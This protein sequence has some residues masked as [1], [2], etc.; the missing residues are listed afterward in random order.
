MR[1][2][3]LHGHAFEVVDL[4][5]RQ[6]GRQYLVLLRS[7]EN[8]HHMSWRLL[9]CLQKRVEGGSRK[10]VHLV[11]NE[12]LVAS[13][14][15]R[16]AR[17]FH[18][19]LYVFDRVVACGVKLKDVERAL[20]IKRLTT[21]THVARLAIGCWLHAVYS[22][23]KDAGT[24]GLAHTARAT[25]QIGMRKLAALDSIL[26]RGGERLLSHHSVEC[27]RAVLTCR[28]YVVFHCCCVFIVSCRQSYEKSCT[29]VYMLHK[30]IGIQKKR[31]PEPH[32]LVTPFLINVQRFGS[33]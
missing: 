22:L 9:Q 31:V 10:H 19:R 30:N 6:D 24:R 29:I 1:H 14:L 18:Q 13:D 3:I 25:K 16:D 26:Q 4:A 17:L 23:S 12:H 21:L 33:A 28:H 11:D 15:R 5:T 8:E 32:G 20:L 7:G 2:R 27:H